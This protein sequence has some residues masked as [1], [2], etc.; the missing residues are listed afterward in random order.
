VTRSGTSLRD[1]KTDITDIA[2]QEALDTILK[3]QPR[4]FRFRNE[5]VDQSDPASVH[6]LQTQKQY[7]LV[8]EEVL[9]V[10]P[11]LIHHDIDKDGNIIPKMWKENAMISL[12]IGAVKDQQRQIVE[13]TARL[14]KIGA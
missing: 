11:E 14:E 2:G 8:V 4:S 13:L 5:F 7:G 1:T 6:D 3:L 10:N 9:E 12:L